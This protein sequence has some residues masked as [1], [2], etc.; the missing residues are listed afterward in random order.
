MGERAEIARS[1]LGVALEG[2]D[3]IRV[4]VRDLLMLA[5]G[6]EGP[7]DA[8]DVRT[9]A[10]STLALAAREIE[11]VATLVQDFRPAPLVSASDS[12]IAQVLLNLVGNALEAMRDRPRESNELVV[13][14]GRAID[15]RLVLEVSDTGHGI[16]ESDLPRVFEPFFT[17]KPAGQGTGLGLAIAQRLV[18]EIGGEIS[19][20]SSVGKG[21]TFRVLLPAVITASPLRPPPERREGA[22]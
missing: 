20:A 1:V 7:V 18:V 21:T 3:R 15:G 2:V 11:R 17:T 14:V 13:R 12:R 19:V 16:P 10:A 8:I 4:I 9:V 22:R 5:R 6:D